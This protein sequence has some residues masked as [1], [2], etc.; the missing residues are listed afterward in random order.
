MTEMKHSAF[1]RNP[2]VLGPMMIAISA[3]QFDLGKSQGS[4]P[5]M[6]FGLFVFLIGLGLLIRALLKM[7]TAKKSQ[8]EFTPRGTE[9]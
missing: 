1:F 9:K 2:L 8:T 6:G 7:R 3:F 4:L 5:I